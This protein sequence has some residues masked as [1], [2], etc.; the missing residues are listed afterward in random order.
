MINFF[1]GLLTLAHFDQNV[2]Y[3]QNFTDIMSILK[4][5][6]FSVDTIMEEVS[7]IEKIDILS[8]IDLNIN[9]L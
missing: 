6:Y 5:H 3:L 7:K 2:R 4:H 1:N 9:L 8:K